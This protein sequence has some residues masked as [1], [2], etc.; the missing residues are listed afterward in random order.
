MVLF[1]Y[2][3]I[4][5][6]H[7]FFSGSKECYKTVFSGVFMYNNFL[8]RGTHQGYHEGP[9]KAMKSEKVP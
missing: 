3:I 1:Y 9:K 4:S 5:F 2:L 8:F 7:Y 6:V